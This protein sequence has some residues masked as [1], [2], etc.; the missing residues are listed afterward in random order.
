MIGKASTAD[1]YND[2][3]GLAKLRGE[4]K[5][6]SPQALREAARQFESVFIQ[7]ALKSMRQASHESSL[8]NTQQTKAY[9]DMYDQQLGLELS[10]TSKL[11]FSDM[12]VRQLGGE[13]GKDGKAPAGKTLGDYRRDALPVIRGEAAESLGEEHKKALRLID[14]LTATPQG[15]PFKTAPVGDGKPGFDGPDDFVTTLWPEAQ[16]AAAELGVDPKMLLAQAALESGWG[17]S[18]P[19]TTSGQASH[20]LFGIKANRSWEG[21]SIASSTLEYEGGKPVRTRAVFRSYDSYADSFRDYVQ[22]LRSNPRYADALQ[23]ADNPERFI[24]GLQKA[25]Y[26][27]DPSY[28]RKVLSIYHGHD[29]FEGLN[30]A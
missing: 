18:M 8:M 9:R 10:K 2:F 29:A 25:G 27:T 15:A 16:K 23:N 1:V 5:G 19:S 17:K 21:Q 20:N 7:M 13:P 14:R 28:A 24:A 12:L 30:V 11:G 3:S 22:F 4:A 26:A 6:K